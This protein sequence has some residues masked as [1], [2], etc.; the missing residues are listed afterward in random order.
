MFNSSRRKDE[1]NDNEHGLPF[2]PIDEEQAASSYSTT[3]S[4]LAEDAT[5]KLKLTNRR[6]RWEQGN[7]FR[8]LD[9][10]TKDVVYIGLIAAI[11]ILFASAE[12]RYVSSRCG[13]LTYTPAKEAVVLEKAKFHA[14]LND[15]TRFRGDPRP[16]LEDAW[17]ELLSA[18]NIRVDDDELTKMGRDAST[19]VKIN[20]GE[21]GYAGM[22]D[23]FHHLHCLRMIR[24]G[25]T[26]DLY[27]TY[28]PMLSSQMGELVPMHIDH[29]IDELRQAVM[30]RADVTVL[31]SD[32]IDWHPKPWLNFNVEHECVNWDNVFQ[33]SKEHWYDIKKANLVHPHFGPVDWSTSPGPHH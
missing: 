2:S 7:L 15:T 33:W 27:P 4:L 20:D 3:S 24:I 18:I 10:G 16:E 6:H 21:G 23:I 8:W 14:G 28:Q 29:C 19:A 11:V 5:E 17:D 12:D 1:N 31:T 9:F 26:L 25:Y 22:L 32:W 13:G 30:C